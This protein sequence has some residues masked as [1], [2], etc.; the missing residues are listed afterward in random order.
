[1]A[2]ATPSPTP[3][4]RAVLDDPSI[5]RPQ[6]QPRPDWSGLGRPG[7]PILWL[8]RNECNDPELTAVAHEVMRAIPPEALSTYAEMAPAYDRLA[9]HFGVAPDCLLAA[10]GSEAAIRAVFETFVAPGDCVVHLAPTYIMGPHFARIHGA[11]TVAVD[12]RR[13]PDGPSL[14]IDDLLAVVARERPRLVYLPNPNSPTNTI[15][16]PDEVDRLIDAVGA[17]GG[18]IL[19]DEA[20]YLFSE[21]T[22]LPRIRDCGHLVVVRTL[23]K[24]WGLAGV[25]LGVAVA[26]PA[27]IRLLLRVTPLYEI[28]ALAL[29]MLTGMLDR[30]AD[31]HASVARLK[32][33]KRYFVEAM[34]QLG[35]PTVAGHGCFVL[36]AFGDRLPAV[37]EAL[38]G[39]AFFRSI[40]HPAMQG[41]VRI[42]TTT[43]ARFE[44]V[45]AAI[46]DAVQGA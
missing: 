34:G 41:Y 27:M 16:R 28:G 43:R 19:V 5:E 17:I 3:R 12:F 13:T 10:S 30:E 6:S 40:G 11:R 39:I 35:I 45:V 25:R 33:G 20:Y 22:A 14:A 2:E 9:D 15:F 44:P 1:M 37:Q 18:V 29:G 38:R 8:D 32:D 24:A 31:M 23:S 26:C 42:T 36:A 46:R 4:P 7:Q 21:H